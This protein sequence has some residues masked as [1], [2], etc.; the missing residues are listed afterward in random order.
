MPTGTP[1]SA[2]KKAA[3]TT[4]ADEPMTTEGSAP[5]QELKP[6]VR[7]VTTFQRGEIRLEYCFE[8]TLAELKAAIKDGVVEAYLAPSAQNGSPRR[9]STW[10][11]QVNIIAGIERLVVLER[12]EYEV[13][14]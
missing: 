1:K 4:K 9:R 10:S 11:S 13:G 7:F 5:T 2:A 8:G 12:G 14:S 6:F 3:T